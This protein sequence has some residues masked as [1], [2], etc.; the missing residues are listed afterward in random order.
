MWAEESI[1]YETSFSNLSFMDGFDA[2]IYPAYYV[3]ISRIVGLLASLV[4]PKNA[5]LVTTICGLIVLL[6]PL[7][8]IIFGKSKY[9]S[10]INQKIV[11]SAFLIFS[12][13]TGEMWMNST[14]VGFIIGCRS[15]HLNS[16]RLIIQ[17]S[18]KKLLKR[19]CFFLQYRVTFTANVPFLFI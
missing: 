11:L 9:W 4:D 5:A 3:L 19:C 13:T 2:I 6:I 14:N 7:V 1:Y 15:T 8:I 17:A 16:Y 12:C 18:F 10:T